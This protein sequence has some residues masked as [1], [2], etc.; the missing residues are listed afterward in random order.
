MADN[1]AVTPGTGSTVRTLQDA[2]SRQWPVGALAYATTLSD[3]AN[4]LQV[5]TTSFGLPVVIE[6]GA[7][8]LPTGASSSAN[9]ATEIASLA[10]IDGKLPTLGQALAAASVP[11]VLTASQLSTLTP[12]AAI[13]GFATEAGNLATL[14]A[15]D[16]ATSAKQPALGT[17]GSAS[18][19]VITVQGIASGVSIPTTI[20][21]A[22]SG[23]WTPHTAI[24]AATT[25][26][27]SVKTSAGQV[28]G[29]T[30][31]NNA[32]SVRYLKLYD[33]ASAPTVGTDIPVM[34]IL[35]PAGGGVVMPIGAG[36]S[37]GTGIA[38]ALTT[39]ITVADATAVALSD[40]AVNLCWK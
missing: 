21:A 33:K 17:A 14:A 38:Y 2:S 34:T 13:T 9:Q 22:T 19:D 36:V 27:T 16:F 18:T 32:A 1:I 25:N 29:F 26:A 6:S 37:F 20:Q 15:K 28:G 12:P 4:V 35:I 10:S 7:I 11:I 31:F 39:G 23:G 30:V 24:S 5:V 8:T 40:V 3:G